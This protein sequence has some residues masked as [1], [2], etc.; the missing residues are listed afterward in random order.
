M[1]INRLINRKIKIWRLVTME[2]EMK[3]NYTGFLWPSYRIYNNQRFGLVI[4]VL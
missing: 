1:H 3:T 2:F 4:S